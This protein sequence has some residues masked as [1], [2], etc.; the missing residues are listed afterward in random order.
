VLVRLQQIA[1]SVP[2]GY[3]RQRHPNE[4][5]GLHRGKIPS[6]C[7]P[8]FHSDLLRSEA[9]GHA[10]VQLQVGGIV[11]HTDSHEEG[12]ATARL[13]KQSPHG[14][15]EI[16]RPD[17]EAVFEADLVG[18]AKAGSRHSIA[19]PACAPGIGD[20]QEVVVGVGSE[21]EGQVGARPIGTQCLG[22]QRRV[23][24][25]AHG[26]PRTDIEGLGQGAVV[27]DADFVADGLGEGVGLLA[28]AY[29]VVVVLDLDV[30]FPCHQ[31]LHISMLSHG[32]VRAQQDA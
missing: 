17:A 6:R 24:D 8:G 23:G 2:M 3:L 25:V 18:N 20:G 7:S 19:V 26:E 5:L 21:R 9:H 22:V 27:L 11:G 12:V 16:L 29:Q 4:T 31:I 15:Y 30:V 32:H 1:D 13:Y 14:C 28:E 10:T